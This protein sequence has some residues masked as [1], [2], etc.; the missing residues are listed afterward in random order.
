[1]AQRG[2]PYTRT[3]KGSCCHT[4]AKNMLLY[5]DVC[6]NASNLLLARRSELAEYQPVPNHRMMTEVEICAFGEQTQP[7]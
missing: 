2:K 6:S 5:K 4:Q 1:M 7:G 3:C